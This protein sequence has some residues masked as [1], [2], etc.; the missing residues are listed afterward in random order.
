LPE[1]ALPEVQPESPRPGFWRRLF[2]GK[3]RAAPPIAEEPKSVAEPELVSAAEPA[4]EPESVALLGASLQPE[5]DDEAEKPGSVEPLAQ[6]A[7]PEPE[8]PPSDPAAAALR[9]ALDSLGRAHH[10]PYSRG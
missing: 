8:A 4:A 10:R 2:G 1:P 3:Q 5:A 9:D 7:R 6:P